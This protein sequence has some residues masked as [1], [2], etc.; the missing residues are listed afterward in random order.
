MLIFLLTALLSAKT[1]ELNIKYEWEMKPTIEICPNSNVT[2]KELIDAFDYW[3]DQINFDYSKIINAP[4]CTP[5]KY[6]TIQI[7][8]DNDY[9]TLRYHAYSTVSWYYYPKIDPS[10]D[11]R[12][13]DYSKVRIPHD[14]D[15]RQE[16]I[17][18]ELGHALG[19]GHSNHEI[20][21]SHR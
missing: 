4:V 21:I 15:Y 18:H 11:I 7:T 14:V 5:E 3:S 20:M 9:N 10:A 13:L 17:K 12:Y 6:N 16:I 19:L 2:K 8:A 1:P